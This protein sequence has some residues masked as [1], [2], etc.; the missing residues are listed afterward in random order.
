MAT[1][2][3]YPNWD[4]SGTLSAST[5]IGTAAT[6]SGSLTA[7]TLAVLGTATFS[8]TAVFLTTAQFAGTTTFSGTAVFL[9]GLTVSG[10]AAVGVANI[11]SLSCS[12]VAIFK[13]TVTVSATLSAG[14]LTVAGV[15]VGTPNY[16]RIDSTTGFA[17]VTAFKSSG[18]W[19]AYYSVD[20]QVSCKGAAT[21]TNL[22]VLLYAD[23]GV[24]PFM[25]YPLNP[26][27]SA[28]ASEMIAFL[29]ITGTK[30][31]H[32]AVIAPEF[33]IFPSVANNAGQQ[34]TVTF[35]TSGINAIGI[36]TGA[37]ATTT[38][39]S[40]ASVVIWGRN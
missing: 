32:P 38:T 29:T 13:G 27:G 11:G 10:T 33:Q 16:V 22:I 37:G 19:S 30:D 28:T 23:G 1:T 8:G 4:V 12:G 15:P 9:T 20:V 34:P 5:I 17:G 39:M 26:I 6:L 7:S 18:T 25:T 35:T 31:G 14:A 21:T 36:C 24:T 40:S 3:V 2:I